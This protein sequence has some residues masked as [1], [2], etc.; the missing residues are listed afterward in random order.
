MTLRSTP[1]P[2]GTPTWLDFACADIPREAAFWHDVLGYEI[3]P[4]APEFGGYT[5]A[6]T[7]GAYVFGLGPAL[8]GRPVDAHDTAIVHLATDDVVG[9]IERALSLGG[10]VVR[11]AVDIAEGVVGVGVRMRV[12]VKVRVLG[13][14]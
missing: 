1:Q 13:R 11:E 2:P 4:G 10:R 6:T 3:P 5:I 8:P 7:A 14:W 9:T 12:K